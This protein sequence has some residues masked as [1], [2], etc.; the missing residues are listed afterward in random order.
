MK[1]KKTKPNNE[2]TEIEGEI[3]EDEPPAQQQPKP[4]PAQKPK[5]APKPAA[6]EIEEGE[7]EPPAPEP[8]PK[9]APAQ[10]PAP[11]APPKWDLFLKFALVGVGLFLLFILGVF[12]Q[13]G[14]FSSKKEKSPFEESRLDR[15]ESM[16]EKLVTERS[17]A[18]PA[19]T[20]ATAP[21]VSTTLEQSTVVTVLVVPSEVTERS[22]VAATP[23]PAPAPVISVEGTPIPLRGQ[24]QVERLEKVQ[25]RVLGE[26][27]LPYPGL[28][29]LDDGPLPNPVVSGGVPSGF[30]LTKHPTAKDGRGASFLVFAKPK[31]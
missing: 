1:V 22:L 23:A 3:E 12:L 25:D 20:P 5:P 13:G 8:K 11:Q 10:D 31:S 16:V 18:P 24:P 30:V 17:P 19:P 14:I 15:L 6:A 21:A 7:E 2:A 9:K 29:L 27:Y 28:V 4:A 26:I